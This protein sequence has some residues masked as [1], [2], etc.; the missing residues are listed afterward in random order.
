MKATVLSGQSLLDLAIQTSGDA[1]AAIEMSIIN[2]IPLTDSLTI[3]DTK[4][5]APVVNRDVANYFANN[6]LTP[7]TALTSTDCNVL[8]VGVFDNTFDNSFE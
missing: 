7:A 3:G 1:V 4:R 6:D 2:D 8:T 5:T